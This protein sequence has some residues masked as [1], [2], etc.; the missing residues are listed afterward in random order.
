MVRLVSVTGALLG[1]RMSKTRSPMLA[2]ATM[3]TP[4]A[5]PWLDCRRDGQQPAHVQVA[6]AVA[7][8]VPAARRV[9]VTTPGAKMIVSSP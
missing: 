5:D 3:A 1:G 9:T 8:V 4:S 7:V 6:V 2:L